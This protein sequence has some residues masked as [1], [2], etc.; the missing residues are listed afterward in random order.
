MSTR[1]KSCPVGASALSP[2]N[3]T[4]V[5]SRPEARKYFAENIQKDLEGREGGIC[6]IYIYTH[7]SCPLGVPA[8]S[9]PGRTIG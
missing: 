1:T 7:T 6:V 8:L 2:P 3:R 5:Q 4:M 9:P